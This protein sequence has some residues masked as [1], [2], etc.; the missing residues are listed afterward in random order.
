MIKALLLFAAAQCF[1]TTPNS[2]GS[3]A[4]LSHS[5][6]NWPNT[7]SWQ[8]NSAPPF[9][10]GA[11]LYG[12]NN[13]QPGTPFHGGTLCITQPYHIV[14][15]NTNPNGGTNG[16]LIPFSTPG[17]WYYIQYIYRDQGRILTSNTNKVN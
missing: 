8:V 11:L 10:Y 16:T 13:T 15:S 12:R 7:A 2:V 6:L 14:Q 1:T 3:G 4:Y 5:G 17:E 9:T